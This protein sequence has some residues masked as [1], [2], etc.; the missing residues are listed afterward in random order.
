MVA[1]S[2]RSL[3]PI[4]LLV[5][6]ACATAGGER[7]PAA[8]EPQVLF[9]RGVAAHRSGD[10]TV[11]EQYL[12]AALER[13]HPPAEVIPILLATCIAGDR[14]DTALHYARGQ[15][16][17]N[18]RN[19]RLRYLVATLHL[20]TGQ[21]ERALDETQRMVEEEPDRPEPRYL[22]GVIGRDHLR[23]DALATRAFREYLAL[24][25][26]GAHASEARRFLRKDARPPVVRK[27]R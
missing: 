1:V 23:D 6:A 14:F 7:P 13:G 5:L 15:L 3:L 18:P 20:A 11:A 4:T 10:T 27:V 26:E 2:V 16:L 12:M 8:Q 22:L 21:D 9:E 17:K 19:W 25:P 24:D